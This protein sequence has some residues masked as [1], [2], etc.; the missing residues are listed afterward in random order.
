MPRW[1]EPLARGAWAGGGALR[2][3]GAFLAVFDLPAPELPSGE[4]VQL[5]PA[6]EADFFRRGPL[7]SPTSGSGPGDLDACRKHC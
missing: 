4:Q 5:R 1:S 7:P 6:V 2:N 3:A